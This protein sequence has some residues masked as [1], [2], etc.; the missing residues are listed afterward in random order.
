MSRKSERRRGERADFPEEN[1]DLKGGRKETAGAVVPVRG[2]LLR[3]HRLA[4]PG[5]SFSNWNQKGW[6]AVF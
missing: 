3:P 6:L 4:S 5:L 1:E 2:L